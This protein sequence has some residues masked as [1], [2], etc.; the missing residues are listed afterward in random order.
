[1]RPVYLTRLQFSPQDHGGILIGI[2][3][4]TQAEYDVHC[5]PFSNRIYPNGRLTFTVMN[6]HTPA[7]TGAEPTSFLPIPTSM[8][9]FPP[10]IDASEQMVLP[11]PPSHVF[12]HL[13]SQRI[14]EYRSSVSM[15][16]DSESESQIAPP[17]QCCNINSS[18]RE[19]QDLLDTFLR[20][21]RRTIVSAGFNSGQSF[22]DPLDT[23]T[24]K[25]EKPVSRGGSPLPP[26]NLDAS[27]H[28][29]GS[30][31]QASKL[32]DAKGEGDKAVPQLEPS[33]TLHPGIWCD[34]CGK[35]IKGLR[36]NCQECPEYDLVRA[37]C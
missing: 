26:L 7:S 33:Q 15:D 1:M 24:M 27:L 32:N 10:S 9:S 4:H 2:E 29:P 35:Q 30:Y 20:D 6:E 36:F 25:H 16:V 17:K 28:I 12:R 34:F 13:H 5:N 21:F 18:K 37:H 11:T 8:E 23:P 14:S 19:V 31:M 22:F 3:V